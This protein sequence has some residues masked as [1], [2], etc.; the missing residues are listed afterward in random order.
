MIF[1]FYPSSFR[2]SGAARARVLVLLAL[3]FSL[4]GSGWWFAQRE[5][6]RRWS[7][8]PITLPE[9]LA[10]VP[11]EW[12]VPMLADRLQKSK[13]IR[14]AAAFE[15]AAREVGLRQVLAGGYLLPAKAGPRELALAFKAGPTHQSVTFPEGFTVLQ[16]G[17]RLNANGF[18]GGPELLRLAY[19]S[20]EPSPLEGRLFPDTYLLP[21]EAKG[22][23][24]AAV[25]KDRFK[26]VTA[27][28][29]QPYPLV[30]ERR[31]SL[32]EVVNLAS[33]VEREAAN[34]QEMP[35]V[36]GVLINRL[37]KPMRLQVDATI[38]YARV[39]ANLAG[40]GTGHKSVLSFKDLEIQSPYNTYR[41]DGL[42]PGP[43]CNPGLQALQAAVKPRESQYF[44]YVYSPKLKRHRFAIT[45]DEHK[46]NI[47]LAKKERV[48]VSPSP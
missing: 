43:I 12:Q 32:A 13:K 18:A 14:V 2:R 17:R 26:L 36:A 23:E 3:I 48:A 25:F 4:A 37:R 5:K 7:T 41:N 21:L 22:P 1:R 10:R 34:A 38:Q 29:P 40:T 6:Y 8:E 16:M 24:L 31:I 42:P 30:G 20:D 47:A 39:L 33:I 15:T 44:F 11:A 35:L 19:P 27:R 9:R 28:L 46:K 45:F